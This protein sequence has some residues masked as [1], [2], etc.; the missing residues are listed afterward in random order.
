MLRDYFRK[1]CPLCLN[2]FWNPEEQDHEEM[3]PSLVTWNGVV[4]DQAC[5]VCMGFDIADDDRAYVEELGDLK[6][7]VRCEPDPEKYEK[8]RQKF[9]DLVRERY[10]VQNVR[11]REMGLSL[12]NIDDRIRRYRRGFLEDK[13]APADSSTEEEDEDDDEDEDADEDDDED[14][15]ENE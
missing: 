3:F 13:K 15:G 9:L 1:L 4:M 2:D 6:G 10:T 12:W 11:K 7:Q 8:G 14:D 5:P